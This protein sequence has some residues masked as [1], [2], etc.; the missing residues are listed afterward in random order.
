MT[1]YFLEPRSQLLDAAKAAA[2]DAVA[3]YDRINPYTVG[4]AV[5]AAAAVLR[6]D[7]HPIGERA[8]PDVWDLDAIEVTPRL[9][10]LETVA[11]VARR[12]HG[13]GDGAHD[14]SACTLCAA[15]R[16]LEAAS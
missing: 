8:R 2:L 5:Q 6:T 10:A 1:T 12:S 9:R 7:A 3:G 4:V 11:E 13:V 14:P 16:H 15:L